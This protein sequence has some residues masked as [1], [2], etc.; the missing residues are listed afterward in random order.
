VASC[1]RGEHYASGSKRGFSI[2]GRRN[3]SPTSLGYALFFDESLANINAA[4]QNGV[5]N[6]AV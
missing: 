5:Q 1:A 3:V 6:A 2:A 4:D